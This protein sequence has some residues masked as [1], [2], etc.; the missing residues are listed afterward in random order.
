MFRKLQ[1][2]IN[3]W[4]KSRNFTDYLMRLL[5]HIETFS[6]PKLLHN[7]LIYHRAFSR[8]TQSCPN[9]EPTWKAHHR[10]CVDCP[11]SAP[12]SYIYRLLTAATDN[13]AINACQCSHCNFIDPPL[14]STKGYGDRGRGKWRGK[15]R[16]Q[17]QWAGIERSP[18][19]GSTGPG[20][21]KSRSPSLR[22]IVNRQ[23]RSIYLDSLGSWKTG[24]SV[25]VQQRHFY[26]PGSHQIFGFG[27]TGCEL[28][29]SWRG[30]FCL[31][32]IFCFFFYFVAIKWV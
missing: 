9:G 2:G 10:R 23:H 26:F 6:S 28:K 29:P 32:H 30:L 22:S 19:S 12:A 8:L 14:H 11:T 13:T 5:Q 16:R 27:W 20:A 15:R 21:L 25:E 24:A 1:K 7:L 4:N 18:F 3:W 31:N 17:S